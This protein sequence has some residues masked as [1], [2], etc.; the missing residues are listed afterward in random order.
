M[1]RRRR[2]D[3]FRFAQNDVAPL[4]YAISHP[5]HA[6]GVYIINSKGI[7]YHQHEVLDIIKPQARYT[8][9]RDEIQGRNAPLMIYECISRRRRVMHSMIYQ[10]CGLDKQKMNFW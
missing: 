6:K 5:N 9:T 4:R 10:A 8:L 3:V 2:Y 7:A 1:H